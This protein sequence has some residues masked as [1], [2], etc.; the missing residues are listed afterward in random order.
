M[1]NI[2][3]IRRETTTVTD[4]LKRDIQELRSIFQKASDNMNEAT[5]S[6]IEEL[7]N[8]AGCRIEETV[9]SVEEKL[10]N[11]LALMAESSQSDA[12]IV[13]RRWDF[14]DFNNIEA[15]C[16]F[17][18]EIV[19][20][21]TYRI[22]MRAVKDL[23]DD[24]IITKSANTLKMSLRQHTFHVRPSVQVKIGMPS[25][26]KIRLG[27]ATWCTLRGFNSEE[28]LDIRLTGNSIL[29][30]DIAAGNARCE[31]SGASRLTGKMILT[32]AEFILS[33]AS[34][35]GLQGSAKNMIL[36]AWGASNIDTEN[37]QVDNMTL[38]MAGGSEAT[39][40]VNN[41]LNINLDSGSR[42]TYLNNPVIGN[43]SVNGASSLSHK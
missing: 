31:I 11:A 8:R 1:G 39:I 38:Q 23:I 37:F 15:G 36:N 28:N 29:E 14:R 33:G 4:R 9:S 12:D 22:S 2:E 13:T 26:N 27:A 34:R 5:Q 19:H 10:H 42:L 18:V 20:S 16:A 43:I 41:N 25:L 17:H 40:N 24:I 30:T 35:I 21:G 7:I 32:D 3:E 6:D